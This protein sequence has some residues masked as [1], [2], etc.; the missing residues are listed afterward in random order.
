MEE[1]RE[2]EISME[3]RREESENEAEEGGEKFEGYKLG[4]LEMTKTEE[5]EIG[6]LGREKIMK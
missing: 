6:K 2:E 1:R 5:E 4:N 3:L